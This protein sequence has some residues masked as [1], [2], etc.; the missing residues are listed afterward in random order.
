MK[1]EELK[2]KLSKVAAND[3]M[4]GRWISRLKGKPAKIKAVAKWINNKKDKK[5]AVAEFHNALNSVKKTAQFPHPQSQDTHTL[6][7]FERQAAMRRARVN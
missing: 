7:K 3:A 1:L 2:V 5:N 6:S 4:L